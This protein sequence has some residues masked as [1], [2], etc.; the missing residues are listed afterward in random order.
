MYCCI[1]VMEH[2]SV[3]AHVLYIF[4]RYYTG[5]TA[6]FFVC[7]VNVGLGNQLELTC[8]ASLCYRGGIVILCAMCFFF[9]F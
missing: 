2:V 5:G 3:V 4:L 1:A 8:V 7:S 9:A 6:V